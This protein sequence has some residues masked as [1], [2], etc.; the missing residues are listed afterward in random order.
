MARPK[1]QKVRR[2]F[3]L[4]LDAK[5]VN[6]LRHAALDEGRPANQ[7]MEEALQEWLKRFRDKR[8]GSS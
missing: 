7:L 4:R 5:L 8:K 3:G 6:E 1:N 2:L